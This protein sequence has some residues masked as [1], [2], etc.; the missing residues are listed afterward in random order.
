MNSKF[1]IK[2][3]AILI[4]LG[5]C[6]LFF[7][8]WFFSGSD[9]KKK[10]KELED[11]NKKIE[12]VRDSLEN[13]NKKLKSD[14]DIKQKDIDERD[15]RIKEIEV[16]LLKTK[17]DL[18]AANKK[19]DQSQKDLAATKKKIEDLKSNPIKRDDDALI[20]SLKEKLGK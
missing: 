7:G 4:L 10:T 16:S 14:Y 12:L 13:V 9:Y 18:I 1:D 19:V 6:I 3:I 8:M 2:T 20:N 11:Q 17:G 5:V 15:N